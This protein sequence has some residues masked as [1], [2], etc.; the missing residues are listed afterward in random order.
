MIPERYVAEG[1]LESLRLGI[2][3]AQ[4][5]RK[6][7]VGRDPELIQ[8][9]K[10]LGSNN[11]HAHLIQGNYG[12][13]KSHM[14]EL[15]REMSIS[16]D[17]LVASV[18]LDSRNGIR[19]N[20]M[21]QIATSICRNLTF[22]GAYESGIGGIFQKF[23][24]SNEKN[25]VHELTSSSLR[26]GVSNWSKS[27]P[28]SPLRNIVRDAFYVPRA[29]GWINWTENKYSQSWRMLNDLD[30]LA[31]M[32]DL[33][34]IVILF[35]EFEDVITNLNNRSWQE[36][37]YHNFFT[38]IDPNKFQGKVF[39]G[40]TPEFSKKTVSLMATKDFGILSE[41]RGQLENVP[42]FRLKSLSLLDFQE[43]A[44]RVCEFH[45]IAYEWD[46]IRTARENGLDK[47]AELA[48]HSLGQNST[49]LIVQQ[50]IDWLD[51]MFERETKQ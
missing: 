6:F 13:G 10:I 2:P 12:E 51:E 48:F 47:Q 5:G 41:V 43:L 39:F 35:D 38:F 7:T 34:G 33:N 9:D 21:D 16:R 28:D 37:A 3:P 23:I 11:P 1:V 4:H 24:E 29:S 18:T 19:F 46:A 45:S 15:I 22:K 44:D 36:S 20:R 26:M 25:A 17:Y 27:T 40:V 32:S 30:T 50:M 14:L 49:R 42:K 31:V 8:L